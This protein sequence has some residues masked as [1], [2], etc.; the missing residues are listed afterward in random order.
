MF[1]RLIKNSWVQKRKTM[2][3]LYITLVCWPPL[4]TPFNFFLLL[5][6]LHPQLVFPLTF[7]SQLGD[8]LVS[9][10]KTL[11][12]N[13]IAHQGL[14]SQVPPRFGAERVSILFTSHQK[15]IILS[16][17]PSSVKTFGRDILTNFLHSS[18]FRTTRRRRCGANFPLISLHGLIVILRS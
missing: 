3:K 15:T 14:Q 17:A 18:L 13:L 8:F 12:Q 11:P 2:K 9:D 6:L 16:L 7:C 10:R 1:R 4:E 5:L